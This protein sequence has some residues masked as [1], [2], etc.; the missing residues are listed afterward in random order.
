M[1]SSARRPA[2]D[3]TVS[4]G[5]RHLGPLEELCRSADATGDLAPDARLAAIAVEH[6]GEVISFDRDFARF[7]DVGWSRP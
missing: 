4:P 3:L 1:P 6:G 5:H 2:E 7:A